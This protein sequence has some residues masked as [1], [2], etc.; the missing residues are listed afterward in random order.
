MT[1]IFV[2]LP[3]VVALLLLILFATL[4]RNSDQQGGNRPFL[5]LIGFTALQSIVVGLRWGYA[6]LEFRYVLPVLAAC[7]P[8]LVLAS[9]RKLIHCEDQDKGA[10]VWLHA[11]PPVV[12]VALL[13]LMP[14]LIDAALI[15]LF[16][17]YAVALLKLG[18]SGPDGLDEARFDSAVAAHRALVIAAA[19]LC[20]S[21]SFDLAVYLDFT[22]GRGRNAALIVSNGNLLGLLLIG[23]TAIVAA[24][25][26]ALPEPAA[27]AGM[28]AFVAAQDREVL[29]RVER[30]INEQKL[31]L[32]E[33]LTLSRLAR[34]AG[35]PARQISGAVNRLAGKN[36]SQ[37]INDFRIAEAC[38]LLRA[39]SSVT[40]AMFECGFQTKSNFN[41]EFRRVTSLSPTAWRDRNRTA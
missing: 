34:R 29:D 30:L 17:G 32:D 26:K 39:N 41:R 5:V 36:V 20:L 6:I 16:V 18:R 28:S 31:F 38:R 1:L 21:A 4:L 7:I 15:T 10:V 40:A 35:V 13:L 22:W 11:L 37:Y 24:R 9:F 8:P 25:A 23:L 2:P 33:S 19:S 14:Q 12:I 3:F 27:E